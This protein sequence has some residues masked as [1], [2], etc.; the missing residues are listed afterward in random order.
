V[1]QAYI[2]SIFFIEELHM[3]VSNDCY[4]NSTSICVCVCVCAGCIRTDVAA[5]L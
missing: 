2:F 1:E 5:E 4:S 3:I